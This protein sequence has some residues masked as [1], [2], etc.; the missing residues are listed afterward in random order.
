MKVPGLHYRNK[1]YYPILGIYLLTALFANFLANEKPLYLSI[2]GQHFFPAFNSN[3]YINL[4]DENNNAKPVRISSIDWK[5]LKADKIIFAP[6]S[7]SPTHSDLQNTYVSPFSRQQYYRNDTLLE[8]PILQRHFLGT[9]KTGNDVLSGLIHG[10]QTSMAIGFFSML[11]S[12]L[13]GSILGGIAGYLGD[14]K[15][16]MSI[17]GII[18]SLMMILPAWFYSF[19]IIYFH[20]KFLSIQIA[21]FICIIT[22]IAMIIWPFFINFRIG[23]IGRKIRIPVDAIISR[24]IEIFLSIPRLIL[25]L[26]IASISRPSLLTII[27]IIGFTSWTEIARLMRSQVLY[28]KE[29]NYVS[30]ARTYGMNTFSILHRHLFPNAF[31]Q[32][33]VVW[34][35]GIAS[36][37]LTEAGLSFLGVGVPVGTA[38]W[39]G[40]MYEAKENFTAWWLIVFTGLA[41]FLLLNSLYKIAGK[42]QVSNVDY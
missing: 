37:I 4:P 34:I 31:S 22:F 39:G 36:A 20:L 29:L 5:N 25:I 13:I 40:L 30:A 9:G 24:F 15:F 18:L 42:V 19:E 7:W 12:V 21:A 16:N 10:T 14:D 1:I 23:F 28:I 8:L 11:I 38:T 26:T 27:I 17:G 33:V 3:A 41:I 32:I 2:H 6:V 35:F